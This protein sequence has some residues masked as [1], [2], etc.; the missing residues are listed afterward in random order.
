MVAPG[1]L[2]DEL[3]EWRTRRLVTAA[4]RASLA[5]GLRNDDVRA[6]RELSQ[7]AGVIFHVLGADSPVT[8]PME[9]IDYL[10]RPLRGLFV[11]LAEDDPIGQIVFIAANGLVVPEVYELGAEYMQGLFEVGGEKDSEWL[12]PFARQVAEQVER[13]V[14]GAMGAGTAEQYTA[15]RRFLIEHPAGDERAL[16]RRLEQMGALRAAKFGPIPAER[17]FG[18]SWWWACPVCRW[19]MRVQGRDVWCDIR[20]HDA[21]Y[22]VAGEGTGSHPALVG[23]GSNPRRKPPSAQTRDGA[24]CV[25]E[26]VWR[27]IVVP[28]VAEL[29]LE[30]RLR[31]LEGID[32]AMWPDY[33]RCDLEVRSVFGSLWEVDVKDHVRYQS[34][35]RRQLAVPYLVVPDHRRNQVVPLREALPDRHVS[36]ARVFLA[37]VRRHVAG[38]ER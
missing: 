26:P 1:D 25:A 35:L 37:L 32:V 20:T 29:G 22:R 11:D 2:T 36:T 13:E 34:I 31:R 7:M 6:W 9:L 16:L 38:G 14:Y 27:F 5:W 12:P 21:R 15:T 24:R 18:N 8:G 28:G 30:R 10:R 4:V 19:P 23:A 33:D 3:R 17:V